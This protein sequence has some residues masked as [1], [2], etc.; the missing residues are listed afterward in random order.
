MQAGV[1]FPLPRAAGLLTGLLLG[2][3]VPVFSLLMQAGVVFPLPIEQLKPNF[4]HQV[5]H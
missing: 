2:L 4:Y 1:V 5:T 3:L